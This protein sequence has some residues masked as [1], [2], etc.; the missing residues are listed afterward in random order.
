M[1]EGLS[2]NV[3]EIYFEGTQGSQGSEY[4]P[5]AAGAHRCSCAAV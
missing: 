4:T 2:Q 5:P 1:S 3:K